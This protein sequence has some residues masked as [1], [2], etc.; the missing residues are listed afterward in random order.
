MKA[1]ESYDH[2][3]RVKAELSA[4]QEILGQKNLF[5]PI[6][7]LAKREE[8]LFYP[9]SPTPIIL[10]RE[11]PLL[12][13]VQRLRDEA[14]RFA[15]THHR[16]LRAK[17]ALHSKL[18]DIPGIGPV[19]RRALILRFGDIQGIKDASVDELI[20]VKGLTLPTIQ[21]LKELL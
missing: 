10:E 14:H 21:L 3:W 16:A 2:R 17:K 8:E 9:D 7:G 11:S 20:L 5:I 4:A 12:F 15:I 6:Y 19:R 1:P 13:L 18:E